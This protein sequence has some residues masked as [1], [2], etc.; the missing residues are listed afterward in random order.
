LDID[1]DEDL[2]RVLQSAA[3]STHVVSVSELTLS[4]N[5]RVWLLEVPLAA[6]LKPTYHCHS[7][8]CFYTKYEA[9]PPR[10][11][12]RPYWF[13]PPPPPPKEEEDEKDEES[14]GEENDD[15]ISEDEKKSKKKERED[16]KE[17]KEKD[18][19]KEPEPEPEK[20][21]FVPANGAILLKKIKVNLGHNVVLKTNV[22]LKRLFNVI[23]GQAF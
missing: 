18:K 16:A 1:A 13:V 19:K 4:P 6:Q 5:T 20:A 2:D 23:Y 3:L 22:T 9:G 8:L 12:L 11:L 17:T 21:L 7:T 15:G 10:A 14:Q